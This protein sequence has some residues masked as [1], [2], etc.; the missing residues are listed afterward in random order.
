MLELARGGM[1]EGEVLNLG[2]L[3]L[4]EGREEVLPYLFLDASDR[5][6]LRELAEEG[7]RIS[8]QDLPGSPRITLESLL[9]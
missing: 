8:A 5:V 9:G 3:H 2:G 4:E 7:V 1:L 6:A